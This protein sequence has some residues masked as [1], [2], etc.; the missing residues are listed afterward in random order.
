M[1]G[2]GS[3]GRVNFNDFFALHLVCI[4][5]YVKVFGNGSVAQ[6]V[7]SK[8]T[9]GTF[10]S[11]NFAWGMAVTMGVYWAGSISGTTILLMIP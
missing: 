3:L 8:N 11:I 7:L 6:A 5:F 9:A 1:I 4:Q 10:L 2:C